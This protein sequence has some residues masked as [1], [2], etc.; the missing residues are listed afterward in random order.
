[1]GRTHQAITEVRLGANCFFF[2]TC[3]NKAL[4]MEYIINREVPGNNDEFIYP[5]WAQQPAAPVQ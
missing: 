1:M 4:K 5:G 2:K 3:F